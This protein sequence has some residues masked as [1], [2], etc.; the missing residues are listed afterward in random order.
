MAKVEYCL[1]FDVIN[2]LFRLISMKS[3][4]LLQLVLCEG[5]LSD[6]FPVS[7]L[8]YI[9]PWLVVQVFWEL[10]D[11]KR[12]YLQN[13]K[14]KI[15]FKTP[16]AMWLWIYG[17]RVKSQSFLNI[18]TTFHLLR[19]FDDAFEELPFAMITWDSGNFSVQH[20][21]VKNC[22]FD[23]PYR[24]KFVKRY[25]LKI[26]RSHDTLYLKNVSLC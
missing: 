2:S 5:N 7:M 19:T 14:K 4:T 21:H 24:Y 13:G 17:P 25:I 8:Q 16:K 18:T 9:Y 26:R 1:D 6:I 3:P 12:V 22:I 15:R 11:W 20:H 10:A 23:S